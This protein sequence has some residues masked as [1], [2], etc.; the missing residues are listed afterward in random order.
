MGRRWVD[1]GGRDGSASVDSE[2][3]KKDG[4]VLGQGSWASDEWRKK[5]KKMKGR[6]E[7]Q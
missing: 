6:R 3:R 2:W 4:L 5:E 1:N 7:G